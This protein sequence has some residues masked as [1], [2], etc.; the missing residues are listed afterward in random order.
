MFWCLL[1]IGQS[2]SEGLRHLMNVIIYVTNQLLL[3]FLNMLMMLYEIMMSMIMI[4]RCNATKAEVSPTD[5]Q[6]RRDLAFN[7]NF[8]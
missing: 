8:Q 5:R 7:Y 3:L 1:C 6:K 4:I 2:L